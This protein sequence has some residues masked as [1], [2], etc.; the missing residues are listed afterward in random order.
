MLHY[1]VEIHD[2]NSDVIGCIM[3][4]DEN[5]NLSPK[6]FDSHSKANVQASLL[7]EKLT[8]GKYTQIVSVEDERN[9]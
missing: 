9:I 7:K 4:E 8:E 5:G 6:K 2:K 3:E 1:L